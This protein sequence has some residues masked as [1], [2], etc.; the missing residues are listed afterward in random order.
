VTTFRL[1]KF[2]DVSEK[3]TGFIFSAEEQAGGKSNGTD[4]G[5]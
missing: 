3:N 5:K 1:F 4:V 2:T